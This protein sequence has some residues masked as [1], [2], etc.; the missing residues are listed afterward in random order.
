MIAVLVGE[1]EIVI[2]RRS[3]NQKRNMLDIVVSLGDRVMEG[4]H[5]SYI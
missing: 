5:A 4:I 2:E 1:A 3:V